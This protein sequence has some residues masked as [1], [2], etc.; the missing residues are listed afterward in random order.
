MR[1]GHF[2]DYNLHQEDCQLHHRPQNPNGCRGYSSNLFCLPLGCRNPEIQYWHHSD[3]ILIYE[4]MGNI[5]VES[6]SA[7]DVQVG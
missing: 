5:E 1:S 6:Q 2:P 7:S 3:G 4:L